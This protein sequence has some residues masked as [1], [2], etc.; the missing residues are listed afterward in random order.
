MADEQTTGKRATYGYKFPTLNATLR[1]WS[2]VWTVQCD[3]TTI[4]DCQDEELYE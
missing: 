4:D 2:L 3:A 1:V